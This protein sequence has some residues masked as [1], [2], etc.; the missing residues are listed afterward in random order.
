MGLSL[1]RAGV[2]FVGPALPDGKTSERRD[3][4]GKTG[5]VPEDTH[6]VPM[7]SY[8]GL[9]KAG[10]SRGPT[11]KMGG[12]QG[13][14][15]PHLALLVARRSLSQPLSQPLL[16]TTDQTALEAILASRHLRGT[17]GEADGATAL[18]QPPPRCLLARRTKASTESS[19]TGSSWRRR[20]RAAAG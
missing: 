15:P 2:S 17:C 7:C 18:I 1:R 4:L 10:G 11:G 12:K 19:C 20:R 8:L 16:R 6:L 14:L 9:A 3:D 13:H 5:T